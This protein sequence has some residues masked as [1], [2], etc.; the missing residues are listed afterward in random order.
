MIASTA[1]QALDEYFKLHDFNTNLQR[2]EEAA[3]LCESKRFIY[4]TAER[5]DDG[6]LVRA[7]H[8]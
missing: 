6:K 8:G 5:N 2:R 1:V 4:R 3:K 7:C